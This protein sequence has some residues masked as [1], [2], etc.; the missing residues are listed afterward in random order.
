MA[1]KFRSDLNNSGV[2]DDGGRRPVPSLLWTYKTGAPVTSSPSIVDGVVYV[3]SH[4][5]NLYALDAATGAFLWKYNT[6]ERNDYVSSSPAVSNGVVYIGGMKTKIHAVDAYSGELLWK[7]KMPIR[8]TVRSG[9][10][11]SAAVA[12]GI[13]YIGNM[14]GTIYA[15]DEETGDP[16]WN[17][18]FTLSEN[19]VDQVFSSPAV[20]DG[21]VYIQTDSG[22]LFAL[23]AR[24]GAL[25]WNYLN[26]GGWSAYG[27]PAVSE[28]AVYVGSG[29]D[30]KF[31]AF[32]AITGDL[33][34]EFS[35][36]GSVTSSAAIANGIVYFG[37]NDNNIYALDA[38]NGAL[39][40]NVTTG[41]RVQ[42][43]PAVADGV[44]Y[45]G[46][47]DNYTYAV[48]ASTG[49]LLWSFD[50]GGRVMS[51]PAVASGVVYIGSSDGNVYAIGTLPLDPPGAD[52]MADVTSGDAPLGVLF[53]DTST[54]VVTMRHWDFGDGTTA[55]ANETPAV[56]HTYP[57]PGTFTVSFTAAN[58]DAA[59][60][61]TM[62][63][64]IR[65]S[66]SGRPPAAWFT[67]TPMSGYGPLSVRFTDRTKG[68][69]TAWRWDF[70][71]GNTS[72]EQNPEHTYATPGTY[73]PMLTAFNSGGSSVYTSFVWVRTKPV[74]P[75]F[76]PTPTI[77][78]KPTIPP[79]PGVPPIAF[80]SMNKSFGSAPLAVQFNDMSFRSPTSW[81]WDFGDGETSTLRN[82]VHTFAHAGTYAVSLSVENSHGR[83][84]TSR[85]VY[86]R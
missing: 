47:N 84:T 60:T 66:P 85:N 20:A 35:A 6:M 26:K 25:L 42:S 33:V 30:T 43:S 21:V 28:G 81:E 71:D 38:S 2:Y 27:S 67:A 62:T 10:S 8:S 41:G 80:F 69:P 4:D 40:W 29:M 48:D 52:F 31:R 70:G 73:T 36:D 24:T 5:R 75:T 12:D 83:S 78:P 46:S 18:T 53:T 32:D 11:S 59:A 34:W 61:I 68:T 51:S 9:I 65:V 45:F 1:R 64:Y 44:V 79:V 7:Y 19:S 63:E 23:D 15:F 16:V 57:F 77:T 74:I 50:V 13:V 49:D 76:T 54:G 55:W 56:S 39:I 72:N 58:P 82:P 14:D 3:G 22:S 37:C 86:V 17:Y